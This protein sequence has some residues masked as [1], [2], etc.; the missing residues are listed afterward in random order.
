MIIAIA[1]VFF[2]PNSR[3]ASAK[4]LAETF[5]SRRKCQQLRE[6]SR[7]QRQFLDRIA[8]HHAAKGGAF[9][10]QQRNG[11]GDFDPLVYGGDL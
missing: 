1:N 10:L 8:F 6:I 9:R 11:G 7:G 2:L 4:V 5:G 3:S